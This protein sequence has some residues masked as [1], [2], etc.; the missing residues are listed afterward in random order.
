MASYGKKILCSR[1]KG[2]NCCGFTLT[3]LIVVMGIFVTVMLITSSSFKTIVNRS[4]QQSK[5]VETQIGGIVGLEIF[6]ADLVQAGFGLPWEFRST[7]SAA[8]YLEAADTTY[9][10][11]TGDPPRAIISGLNNSLFGTYTGSRYIV[12]KSATVAAS[13]TSKKWTNVSYAEGAKKITSWG[14]PHRDF[15]ANDKVIVVKNSLNTN[16]P[17]RQLMVANLS[18]SLILPAGSFYTT[19]NNYSALTL[20][21][22]DGDTFQV[23]GI[24][25]AAT[26]AIRMPFNRA[27]YYISNSSAEDVPVFCAPNAG[28]LY[29]ATIN[30]ADGS[31]NKMPLLD[32]VADMQIV[33]G[34]DNNGDGTIDQYGDSPAT[35]ASPSAADIRSQLKEIRVYILAQDGKKDLIFSYPS[36]SVEVGETL[37]GVFWGRRYPIKDAYKNYRWKVY[38]IVVRPN[39]LIQ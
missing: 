36:S 28:V 12:I 11:A 38:T 25:S 31:R 35:T 6:R 9:N 16:P 29:K 34:L 22:R 23:Y 20:P 19:F 39:N 13:E 8:T 24:A 7:P 15:A 18:D 1:T 30:H 26:A 14:D 4:S 33:Y 10:D 27:D 37:D 32:C 3:E 2:F 5:S 21:H 17:T